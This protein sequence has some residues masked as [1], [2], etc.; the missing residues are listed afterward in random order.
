MIVAVGPL[1]PEPSLA[2][3]SSN[4]SIYDGGGEPNSYSFEARPSSRKARSTGSMAG[5]VWSSLSLASP[6][7]HWDMALVPL[8]GTRCRDRR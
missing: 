7:M 4:S 5:S 3:V 1:S 2:G 8:L 6:A